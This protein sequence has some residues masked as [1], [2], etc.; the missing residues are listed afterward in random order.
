[1]AQGYKQVLI[2]KRNEVK[3]K[4]V[5]LKIESYMQIEYLNIDTDRIKICLVY[6]KY[7]YE[8]CFFFFFLQ[9]LLKKDSS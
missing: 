4:K 7:F 1:M 9:K 5:R 3:T 6:N 8:K 2:W